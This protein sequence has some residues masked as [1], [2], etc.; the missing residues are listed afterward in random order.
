MYARI[1]EVA[2][3]FMHAKTLLHVF[4]TFHKVKKNLKIQLMEKVLKAPK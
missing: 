1:D 3:V 2:A 4:D